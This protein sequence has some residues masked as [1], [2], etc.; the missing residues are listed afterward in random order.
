MKMTSAKRALFP[1][2]WSVAVV[3][4]LWLSMS[5]SSLAQETA[6]KQGRLPA[7][8]SQMREDLA[9]RSRLPRC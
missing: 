9:L 2:R 4:C 7:A 6:G 1:I 8:P 3:A 5:V